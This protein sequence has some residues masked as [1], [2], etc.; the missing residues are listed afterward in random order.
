MG[1]K[2]RFQTD[3][4][5]LK[6]A[7]GCGNVDW[8][9]WIK[10]M[11]CYHHSPFEDFFAIIACCGEAIR[12]RPF[13]TVRIHRSRIK[14]A[15]GLCVTPRGAKEKTHWLESDW[16]HATIDSVQGRWFQ[17]I[18]FHKTN[19]LASVPNCL[20]RDPQDQ[21]APMQIQLTICCQLRLQQTGFGSYAETLLTRRKI[22]K[23]PKQGQYNLT[24]LW[25]KN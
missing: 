24:K 21:R 14:K 11:R 25:K 10:K 4:K 23:S 9:L 6:A 7:F 13:Q 1:V 17:I 18:S 5:I 19:A 22:M 2:F 8:L 20:P 3:L 15:P 16:V 12:S